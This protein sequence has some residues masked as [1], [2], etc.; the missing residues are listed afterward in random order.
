[1]ALNFSEWKDS[2]KDPEYQIEGKSPKCPKGHKWDSKL[3][4]CVPETNG[5]TKSDENPG[6]RQMP[7]PLGTYN[8]WGSH[9]LNGEPPAMAVEEETIMEKPIYTQR[10]NKDRRRD[11][12]AARR[13]KEQD[14][15][16]RYGKHGKRR[17][18]YDDLRPG[19]VKRWDD[20][21]KRWVSNKEGK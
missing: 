5:K 9:G 6:E 3:N 14:D 11:E 19:E 12:E 21:E 17:S 16:M 2:H 1:M 20:V 4:T 8:V 7:E 10:T 18:D 15:R 13:H